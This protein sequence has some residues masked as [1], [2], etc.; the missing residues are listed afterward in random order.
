MRINFKRTKTTYKSKRTILDYK[1][2]RNENGSSFITFVLVFLIIAI[3]AFLVYQ[4]L[5]A[6]IFGIISK[7]GKINTNTE[8]SV[9]TINILPKYE[10]AT[11]LNQIES[12]LQN[13]QV[14]EPT[15]N[16]NYRK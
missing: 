11:K 13:I 4:V 15:E 9:N 16:P 5:Y 2:I 14:Y 6:D 7:E 1:K 3:L 12:N 10:N 8:D